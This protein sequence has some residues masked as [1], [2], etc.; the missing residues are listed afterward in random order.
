MSKALQNISVAAAMDMLTAADFGA[1]GFAS[2]IGNELLSRLFRERDK[3]ARK[4]ALE[5]ISKCKRSSLDLPEADQFVAIVYRYGRAALEGAAELNLRILAKIISGQ[6]IEGSMYASEFDEF[7]GVVSNLKPT[8]IVYLGTILRL[9]KQGD[10]I[11]KKDSEELYS[12][13]QSVAIQIREALLTTEH[14]AELRD[15]V[16]CEAGLL[17]TSLIY[18]SMQLIGSTVYAPTR[19]LERLSDLVKFEDLLRK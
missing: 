8:E 9:Y 2:S 18:P 3:R 10:R 15:I 13:E 17:R 7:A 1:A 14:F 6:M 19:D 16:S 12:L 5:E 11:K 4:I